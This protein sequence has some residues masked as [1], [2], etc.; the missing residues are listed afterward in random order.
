[1]TINFDGPKPLWLFSVEF[2]EKHSVS[3]KPAQNQELKTSIQSESG[4]I[5]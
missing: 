5:L 1:M 4:F 2:F 3:E